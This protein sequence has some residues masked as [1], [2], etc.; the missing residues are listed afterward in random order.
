MRPADEEPAQDSKQA[1]KLRQRRD[2]RDL[3]VEDVE[4]LED[5]LL[6]SCRWMLGLGD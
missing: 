5:D 6:K 2:E 3:A 1:L 4:I